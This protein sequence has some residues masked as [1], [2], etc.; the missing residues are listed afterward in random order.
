MD[1]RYIGVEGKLYAQGYG[2]GGHKYALQTCSKWP[3][4]GGFQI[5]MGTRRREGWYYENDGIPIN[6]D[7]KLE[8][9]IVSKHFEALL[10]IWV[11]ANCTLL[12]TF[13]NLVTNASCDEN[14]NF[15]CQMSLSEY[16]L[17]APK[18]INLVP[19]KEYAIAYK[20][21]GKSLLAT[22]YEA[23]YICNHIFKDSYVVE[24]INQRE[25]QAIASLPLY[26]SLWLGFN[27]LKNFMHW[28]KDSDGGEMTYANFRHFRPWYSVRG[29]FNC[30]MMPL[31]F[32]TV[33]AVSCGR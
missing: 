25:Q 16:D 2:K 30:V 29:V 24:P 26:G 14:H 5:N 12:T 15:V 21:D 28:V 32:V 18:W 19:G 8:A 22:F 17:R 33:A 11:H 1:F 13:G 27:A 31:V 23:R 7:S 20:N 3:Y 9:K 10:P 4:K 6:I